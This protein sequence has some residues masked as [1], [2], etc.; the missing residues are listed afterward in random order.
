MFKK[1]L[2]GLAFCL[3]GLTAQAQTTVTLG[4][5][6]CGL[7]RQCVDIPNDAGLELSLYSSPTAA[8]QFL[9]VDSVMYTGQNTSPSVM[10]ASDGSYL[11]LNTAWSTYRTCSSSGRGQH[12]STH[13]QL[14][15]GTVT[16]P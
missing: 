8:N 3:I 13:W 16:L 4:P 12:C 9:F 14:T 5:D 11:T 6:G 7:N 10:Y 15:G 2:A 1:I